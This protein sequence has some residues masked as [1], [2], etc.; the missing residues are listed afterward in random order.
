M[1]IGILTYHRSHNYGALLQAVA[2]RYILQ[3]T[4]H[5]VYYA[6]YFPSYHKRVYKM[7]SWH[8]FIAKSGVRGKLYYLYNTIKEYPYKKERYKNFESFIKKEIEPYSRSANEKYDIMVYGSDQIWRIQKA[9]GDF[10]SV[11]FGDNMI[12][13]QRRIS[14]AASMGNINLTEQKRNE[15]KLLL[16]NFD[17]ISVREESLKKLVESLGFTNVSLVIDPTLLLNSNDWDAILPHRIVLKKKYVLL[18]DLW[19]GSFNMGAVKNFASENDLELIEITGSAH[20]KGDYFYRPTASPYEFVDLIRNADFVFTSSF[21]GL[22]FSLLFNRQFYASFKKNADRAFSLLS[23]LGIEERMIEVGAQKI[24]QKK[25]IDYVEV[26]EYIAD[27][28]K[29]SLKYLLENCK[30]LRS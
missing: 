14:Y 12:Q 27:Y 2:T 7:F 22:V 5:E 25:E 4:G 24:P 17:S 21:H 9:T 6:D 28:R 10:N 13:A 3:S 16:N 19:K 1:K 26:N 29:A 23:I 20:K 30:Y 18:Y 15:L 8:N 11:Y